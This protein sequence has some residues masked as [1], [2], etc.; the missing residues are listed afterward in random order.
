ML[1]E[2]IMFIPTT[3]EELAGLGW[4]TLDIILVSGDAYIDS[5]F[6]GCA[7]IG[8]LL[9]KKGF[10]VGII[11]QPDIKSP[12]DITRL[13]EPSLYWGVSAGCVDSMVAN[14]TPSL[15]KRRTD[16]FTPCGINNKRP[17]RAL[18]AYV[19]L[20]RRYYKNTKPIV[21]GGIEA[22]LRRIAHYDYWDDA[23]RRPVLFDSK[24][25]ILIYGMG[26]KQ[27]VLLAER[28][29]DN[30]PWNDIKG[31]CFIS[32]EK[33]TGIF[34]DYIRLPDYD[35]VLQDKQKF[36]DMFRIFYSNC[37]DLS[38][39]GLL[40]RTGNRF[41]VHNPPSPPS[42]G[43]ELDEVYNIG[44]ERD[45]HPFYKKMGEVRAI[46]TI[47][48]SIATHRG[49]YG[50]CRFCSI[51][52]HQGRT[53]V[54]RSED[55]ILK[56]AASFIK[57]PYFRGTLQLA[58]G[59]TA[60]MYGTGCNRPPDLPGCESGS[61]L[62]P[63]PCPNLKL[64]HKNQIGLLKKLKEMKT[65]KGRNFNVFVT[66]GIRHDLVLLD[67]KYGEDYL[68]ILIKDHT[69][70][71]MKLAPEHCD[72]SVLSLMGKPGWDKIISFKN[73]FDRINNETG[74]KQFLTYY[75]IAAHPGCTEASMRN[76]SISISKG[77]HIRPE[78]VQIFTPTPSTYSTVMYYTGTDPF[79]GEKL[80][81]EKDREKKER[82]K[83]KVVSVISKSP[84]MRKKN[85]Y[86]AVPKTNYV[87]NK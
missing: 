54:S 17:D 24:A 46:E 73:I 37:G 77:L 48:F 80:F 2:I 56:E 23:I 44:Y 43:E 64:S 78:Q 72:D 67:R 63:R 60:N 75:F 45:V 21:L 14:Y 13:G 32:G 15:K 5:P 71:Q 62:F 82:Q 61:C 49:C 11:S 3:P 39:T 57:H 27:A 51:S 47:R 9:I 25:D 69:S 7:I 41:L 66:S 53:V 38:S 87:I 85:D 29:K 68:R 12:G 58:G 42:T 36:I 70:G 76:L 30:K 40:Q 50:G 33:E 10:R 6:D 18:I 4:K 8:Q 81:V 26:E 1:I 52:V 65:E 20:I 55:S 19:N 83:M 34:K 79:T 59:P 84:V 22:S 16:D 74:R 31:I 35:E 28:L 86:R